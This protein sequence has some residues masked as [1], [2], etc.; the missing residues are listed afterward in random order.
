MG[1]SLRVSRGEGARMLDNA[2]KAGGQ[3]GQG[4]DGAAPADTLGFEPFVTAVYQHLTD[5]HSQPPLTLSVEG[6]WGSG[7]SSFM[8]QL[9]RMIEERCPHDYVVCFNAWRHDKDE[10]VWAAFAVEFVRQ[11]NR[12]I[13]RKCDWRTWLKRWPVYN[14]LGHSV[15]VEDLA[16]SKIAKWFGRR[17]LVK[18]LARGLYFVNPLTWLSV[19]IWACWRLT[20]AAK[21]AVHRFD[22]DKGWQDFLKTASL[23]VLWAALGFYAIYAWTKDP[24]WW[25]KLQNDWP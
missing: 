19:A 4:H 3:F 8:L 24:Q 25:D 23:L 5:G 12:G 6:E 1:R 13:R 11:L 17:R 10:S 9:R 20:L 2:R 21:L 14:G 22:W 15:F 16:S 7:K 18:L